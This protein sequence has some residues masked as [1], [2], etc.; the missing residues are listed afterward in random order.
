MDSMFL[1]TCVTIHQSGVLIFHGESVISSSQSPKQSDFLKF[2]CCHKR[3]CTGY[4]SRRFLKM[5]GETPDW[6][7]IYFK[8]NVFCRIYFKKLFFGVS[9]LTLEMPSLF[10]IRPICRSPCS[11]HQVSMTTLT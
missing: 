6:C 7:I 1:K 4:K 2:L 8:N 10:S 11:L 3:F 5:I 9:L